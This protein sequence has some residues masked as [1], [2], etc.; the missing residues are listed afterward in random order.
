M[1]LVPS[2]N[3]CVLQSTRRLFDPAL[4]GGALLDIGVYPLALMAWIF[5]QPQ[6]QQLSAMG[7]LSAEGGDVVGSVQLK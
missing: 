6:P 2:A 1:P 5:E 7:A 3:V 4:G